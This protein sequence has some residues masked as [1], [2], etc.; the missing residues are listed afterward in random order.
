MAFASVVTT[1]TERRPVLEARLYLPL[2]T[3]VLLA[4]A[5]PAYNSGGAPLPPSQTRNCLGPRL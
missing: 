5:P 3:H 4:A 2:D 1:T